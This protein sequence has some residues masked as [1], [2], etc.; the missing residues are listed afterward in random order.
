MAVHGAKNAF[1]RLRGRQPAQDRVRDNSAKA[2]RPPL[3]SATWADLL[4]A[5]GRS[6]AHADLNLDAVVPRLG[7]V[8][9]QVDLATLAI[10]LEPSCGDG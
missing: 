6:V 4:A 3:P 2:W 10:G 7:A 9:G 1:H 5:V 8:P